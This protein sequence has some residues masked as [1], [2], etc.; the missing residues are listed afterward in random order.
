[1]K[2]R[3]LAT[4]ALVCLSLSAFAQGNPAPTI[5]GP[6]APAAGP[7]IGEITGSV[8]SGSTPMPGV[9]ITA[10]NTLTG[11]KVF[12]STDADGKYTLQVTGKGRYVIKAELPAF[13]AATKEAVVNEATPKH[14]I[15]MEMMLFSRAQ[16]AAA[17]QQAQQQQAISSLAGRGFQNLGLTQGEG[18]GEAGSAPA[19]PAGDVGGGLPAAAMGGDAATESVSIAGNMGRTESMG[20]DSDAMQDRIQEMRDRMDRGDM[21]MGGGA[22]GP[23]I[24]MIG[25]GGGGGGAGGGGNISIGG[26]GGPMI[27]MGGAPGG[28]GRGGAGGRGRF[29]I[30]Q[31]HGAISYNV[32]SSVLDARPYSLTGQQA[33]KPDYTQHRIMASIGG[34]LNIPR[35]YNGGAKTFYFVNYFAN[36]AAN[37]FDVFSTV[38]TA[39]ER[40]GDFSSTVIR[41]GP[42]AG[43]PVVIYDPQTGSP[44]LNNQIPAGRINGA[45]SGLLRFFPGANQADNIQNFHRVT[46]SDSIAHNVNLRLIHNFGGGGQGGGNP[47]AA[48]MGGRNSVNFGFNYRTSENNISNFSPE[49][50][51][52]GHA[53]GMN[54][55]ASWV[56]GIKKITSRLSFN[57][58]RNE[59]RNQNLYA[60]IENIEGN[61]GIAGVSTDPFDWGAPT[62]SFT[63]LS[64]IRDLNPAMRQDAS[65][66]IS[67]NASLR[68]KKHNLRFGG[69]YRRT[70]LNVRSNPN[71][72]GSFTFTGFSTAR[73]TLVSGVPVRTPGTGYDFADFL[74]GL[75]QQTGLQFGANNYNFNGNNYSLFFQDDW[76]ISTKLSLNLGLRYEYVGPLT[77]TNDRLVNLDAAGGFTAVAPVF[78]GATGAFSG[79]FPKSLVNPDRNNFAPRVG[80]AWTPLAKTVIRAGYGINYNVGAY[81][82]FVQQ[83]AFQPPF[84]NT[85]TNV[86]S[87][88][89]T[90]TLQ[91]GFP[92]TTGLLTNN[93]GVDRDYR[94]GYVQTW[95]LDTQRELRPG[96]VLNVGYNGAKGT[97]LDMQRAPNRTPTGLRI[98]GVQAFLWQSSEAASILH[99]GSLRLRKRMQKGIS[100]GGSYTFSKSIDNASSIGGGATVVAQNDLDLAAERG[101]SSFD[102]RHRANI[103]YTIELPFGTNKRWLSTG[104]AAGK[105]FGDWTIQGGMNARS[106]TPFTARVIG[107]FADVAGG[108]NG[109][110]RAN[111]TGAPISISDPTAALFFN[112]AAFVVPVSGQYGNARRN[113]I[114][115][116]GAVTFDM[117]LNKSLPLKDTRA[118]NFRMQVS[119]LFNHGN[120]TGIDAVVN[121]PSYGRVTS[122]GSMRRI[123]FNTQF[124]F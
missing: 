46:S 31:P 112:T 44:F 7:V 45:A 2:Q 9:S 54:V 19:G 24:I 3:I 17:Q 85:S 118:L 94:L 23:G 70:S 116:P 22:G 55:N 75:P 13:A 103:D 81:S 104:N 114:I 97:R 10:S 80:I 36:I 106:G 78:P 43:Q 30:N 35:I 62:L 71:P 37:P 42:N 58:N 120:Y 8:K 109:T 98:P 21:S 123:Q 67:E 68:Y 38:P 61:L 57:Y 117:G 32:G 76:R 27:M 121:S 59:S 6:S 15:D 26:G 102:Q 79:T 72:R 48:L 108:V 84:S 34:P 14:T 1:M 77:E 115:G 20:F 100:I 88:A 11:R 91:N 40:A 65:Y 18:M 111:V 28:G 101:L 69:D 49:L 96:L 87:A 50:G 105:I 122:V 5:P 92:A 93:F 56:K 41:S 124:R 60:G 95:N 86:T 99:S 53:N 16:A 73:T 110:L 66:Q 83:L 33:E 113:T 89:N 119:N 90:L 25:P 29:N 74:L 107:G 39:A 64:T 12:T 47:L 4:L 51:G 82:A 63:N 52:T